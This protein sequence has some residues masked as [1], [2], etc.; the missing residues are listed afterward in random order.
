MAKDLTVVYPVIIT[1][2]NEDEDYPYGVYIPAFDGYTEG[3]SMA[4]AI[5]MARDFIGLS[6]MDLR[7]DGKRL[8]NSGE[9]PSKTRDNQ[10]VTLV[11][12]N[13]DEYQRKYDNKK[14]DKTVTIPNYLNEAGIK[15]NINFSAVLTSALKEKLD[16]KRAI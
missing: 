3:T 1:H 10:I 11:D 6:A 2:D 4:D 16:D 15:E 14:I 12:V 7:E 5:F 8:P 9:L 13:V